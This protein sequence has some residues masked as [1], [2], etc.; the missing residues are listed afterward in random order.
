MPTLATALLVVTLTHAG[1]GADADLRLEQVWT[2][3]DAGRNAAADSLLQVSF[4]ETGGGCAARRALAEARRRRCLPPP[5]LPSG[6]GP[7]GLAL[8]QEG[9]EARERGDLAGAC[10]AFRLAADAAAP[11]D[12]PGAAAAL[13]E[14]ADCALQDHRFATADT[15]LDG[16]A[17]LRSR[18]PAAAMVRTDLAVAVRAAGVAYLAGRY[19][20]ADSLYAVAAVAA[21][22]AGLT[23]EAC[24]ALN[25]CG[26]TASRQR[27][28]EDSRRH[29]AAALDL[30]VHLGDR[31][32]EA[33]ILLNLAY[34]ET[35]ARDFAAAEAHLLRAQDL[36]HGCGRVRMLGRIQSGLGAL[37]EGRG[38]RDGAVGRF[39][40]A[41]RAFAA[42]GDRNGELGA[43]QWL[44]Y[45]LMMAGG[46]AEAGGHYERA[47]ALTDTLAS[48]QMLNWV[49]AG[50]ALTNHRLGH[51]DQAESYYLR[52]IAVNETLGD[53]MSVAWCRHSLGLLE[54]LRG[55]YREAMLHNLVAREI[56][57]ELGDHEG[58]GA[59]RVALA[60]I[61]F[62]LGDWDR[63][64]AEYEVAVAV[65]REFG[66]EE[67][68]QGAVTGL[69]AVC[70]AAGQPDRA[71]RYCEEGLAIARRWQDSNAVVWAL[72]ELAEQC[73][74]AGDRASAR[75]HLAEAESRLW[76]SGP[77]VLR[78]RTRLT[79]ARCADDPRVALGL[80]RAAL[81]WAEEGG[82]PE[83]EWVCLT[84]LGILHLA[85]G[86]TAR[87]LAAQAQAIDVI[88]SLRRNAGSDD[89]RRHMLRPALV[90]YERMIALLAARGAPGD[91]ALAL[92]YAERSRARIL[93][94]RL[95]TAQAGGG[96]MPL[97]ETTRGLLAA[98]GHCQDRLQDT[99]LPDSARADLRRRVA[100]LEA[101]VQVAGLQAAADARP[102][103][104]LSAPP[105]PAELLRIPRPGEQV[106]A[107]FLG[108]EDSWLFHL[109]DGRVAVHALPARDRIETLVRR[110]LALREMPSASPD[111]LA[112]AARRLHDVLLA[113][114]LAGA[115]APDMLIIVPDGLLHRLPF[116]ALAD[117]ASVLA[118]RCRSFIAPSLQTLAT[119]R[120]RE[121]HRRTE[122]P[123][124]TVP[125]VAV[126][127]G[128]PDTEARLHPWRDRP[129]APLA[130]ADRE[131]QEVAALFP[132]A[133]VL[134][135]GA[136]SEQALVAAPLDRTGILHL[137]V[138]GDADD[139]DVRRS[140]VLL[141][142]GDGGEDGL[143]QWSEVASLTLGTS[144]VTLSSCRSARGVL[145]VGEGVT[146][147]TQAFLFAGA[148]CVLAA[149]TDV[150]DAYARRFMLDFYGHLRT[151]G[152]AADA[153][154]RAQLAAAVAEPT[155]RAAWADF[156]LVG[157]AV[158][159]CGPPPARARRGV[160]A[161]AAGVLLVIAAAAI[162]RHRRPT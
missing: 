142:R 55:N 88:E 138:H 6:G 100:T 118:V 79:Q 61:H 113:P 35:Q 140:F 42:V 13:L 97:D 87:A 107:Y 101:R 84:E 122:G 116:A 83:R 47:L 74:A 102:S 15:V 161:V 75:G 3:L 154:R 53:R 11:T 58:V 36:V 10:A 121:S 1:A 21:D 20:I 22:V 64:V 16:L 95:R 89:L 69:A 60:D 73:L 48:P 145:A 114:A 31:A 103:A 8:F 109:A 125:L 98:I 90:P 85:V 149:Q 152:T 18:L 143:L 56:C 80:A 54:V 33:K 45:N 133:I 134:A 86:D 135:G 112:T 157:D 57:Q 148:T 30:A 77:A 82:L 150:G 7:T 119:L 93:A 155:A 12:P 160:S 92:A 130:Q 4:S 59:A 137:A 124:P 50:L 62:K 153:L 23:T 51:L 9:L 28:L 132:G 41:C 5:P 91:L 81:E 68:M 52:A 127:Y 38:D 2:L 151:G 158:T 66:L 72:V 14:A 129:F 156:V 67:L 32:R 126:G 44:G 136:A 117:S 162:A 120:R 128:G 78:S 63:A 105:D 49:L 110:Y 70:A 17:A 24:D 26:A 40:A 39:R 115:P 34:D 29:Y 25:G 37:A 94:E 43:R 19:G 111:A 123:R 144:L 46:Y 99:D 104:F 106:L 131:A 27:R 139:R 71:R 146:G 159:L 76:P 141:G 147:L 108:S 65:A 96:P